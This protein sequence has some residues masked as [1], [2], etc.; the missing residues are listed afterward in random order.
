MTDE[1]ADISNEE[2][3]VICL[4]WVDN[5]LQAHEN[6]VGLFLLETTKANDIVHALKVFVLILC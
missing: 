1:T 5:E 6:F 3:L 2:Q 4:R